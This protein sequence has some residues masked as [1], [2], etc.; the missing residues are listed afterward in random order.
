MEP[1]AR[2]VNVTVGPADPP[3]ALGADVSEQIRRRTLA[4]GPRPALFFLR[5]GQVTATF[6]L[7]TK[8]ETRL[9]SVRARPF[10]EDLERCIQSVLVD[11]KVELPAPER[12]LTVSLPIVIESVPVE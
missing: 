11:V 7:S 10:N 9:K 6:K 2:Q 1:E 3:N 4:C 5:G 12:T 8:G